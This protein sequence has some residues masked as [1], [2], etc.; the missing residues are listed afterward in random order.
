MKVAFQFFSVMLCCGLIAGCGGSVNN[1][2]C[3]ITAMVNPVSA[4]ASHTA[5]SPGNQVQF[6]TSS[7]V[8]GNCPQLPDT[9]GS[10]ST[11]DPVNTSISNQ[12]GSQ[13][14]ATCVN[15]TTTPATI[16]NSSTVRG[17][18]FASATLTCN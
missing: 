1:N 8:V 4:T 15:A 6:S 12:A 3:M 2:T 10:W 5:A 11:S 14:L 17:Q 7:S 18:K 13:G 9:L 16:S